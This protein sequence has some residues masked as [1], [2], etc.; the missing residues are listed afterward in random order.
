MFFNYPIHFVDSGELLIYASIEGSAAPWQKAIKSRK[1][2]EEKSSE[3][4]QEIEEA[5]HAVNLDG[6]GVTASELAEYLEV[7]KATATE[8]Y[9]A[10]LQMLKRAMTT[11]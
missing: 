9:M 2:K 11:L 1:T 5:Y 6:K 3:R 8:N 10:S 7:T 4:I